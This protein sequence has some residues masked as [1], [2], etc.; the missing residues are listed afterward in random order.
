MY[1]QDRIIKSRVWKWI[2]I[3]ATLLGLITGMV[4]LYATLTRE[5]YTI[6]QMVDPE[7]MKKLRELGP[8]ESIPVMKGRPAD[9]PRSPSN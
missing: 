9:E 5:E 3:I 8:G 7:T 1:P 4:A 6:E 2:T